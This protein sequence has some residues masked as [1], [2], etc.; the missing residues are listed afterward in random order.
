MPLIISNVKKGFN[1]PREVAKPLLIVSIKP[2]VKEIKD[3]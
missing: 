3:E 1:K 2:S